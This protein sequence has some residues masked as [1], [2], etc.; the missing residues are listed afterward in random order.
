VKVLEGAL[1]FI[2]FMFF[3]TGCEE[4]LK[5]SVSSAGFGRDVPAQESWDA[6]ITFTDSGRITGVLHSGHIAMFSDRRYTVLDSNIT[7]DFFDEHQRHT[8]VLTARRGLVNDVTHDFEAHENVVVT[9]D[10]GT[11]MKTESLY[12]TNATQ[13]VHTQAFVDITS[14]TEKIQGQGFE[15]DQGLKHY[16]IFRVTG[17]AKEKE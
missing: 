8:S 16:T 17:Q 7:V 6:T 11:T 4:K 10:S 9:S 2:L 15:S 12:W 14:P 13:K 3:F 1:F 5:P